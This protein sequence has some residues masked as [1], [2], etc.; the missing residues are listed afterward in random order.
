[1]IRKFFKPPSP[2]GKYDWLSSI[3]IADVMEQYEKKYPD[4]IFLGPVPIDFDEILTEVGQMNLK[5]LA[6]KKKRIGIVFNT[7]PHDMPGEHWISMF[8]DLNDKTI[9]FFDSTGAV[10]YTHLTLPTKRI[11]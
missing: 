8:I 2:K 5:T 7:D 6:N 10:S 3:D 4:F 1:M 11:V 9:C